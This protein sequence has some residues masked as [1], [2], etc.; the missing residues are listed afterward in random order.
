MS[1]QSK[2]TLRSCAILTA[3][4]PREKLLTLKKTISRSCRATNFP[5]S[6]PVLPFQ[7]TL[8]GFAPQKTRRR[9][10]QLANQVSW[11]ES[12]RMVDSA[13]K[14]F[15]RDPLSRSRVRHLGLGPRRRAS[16]RC[17][18]VHSLE[19]FSDSQNQRRR[20]R[21]TCCLRK[22]E[23]TQ[24]AHRLKIVTSNHRAPHHHTHVPLQVIICSTL[25]K[26]FEETC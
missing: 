19:R 9:A 22:K 5:H 20:L 6:E 10:P 25:L 4:N 11:Q 24:P 8:G 26:K 12:V 18:D 2:Q 13:L 1:S 3:P 16:T 14:E 17:R 7:V 15:F 23:M 21:Q